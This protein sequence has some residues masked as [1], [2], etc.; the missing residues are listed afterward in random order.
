MGNNYAKVTVSYCSK[1]Y[2]PCR[3]IIFTTRYEKF[4]LYCIDKN[5]LNKLY[6][7]LK[8]HCTIKFEYNIKTR[9]I[10][11]NITVIE[12]EKVDSLRIFGS[13]RR[14]KS[15]AGKK[16]LEEYFNSIYK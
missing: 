12:T 3:L 14:K 1:N 9:F 7:R 13:S 16:N 8:K 15:T 10:S 4:I 11:S 2:N 6:D 5:E